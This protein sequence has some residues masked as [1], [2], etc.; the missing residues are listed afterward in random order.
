MVDLTHGM[1][2]GAMRSPRLGS[3]VRM[4][5]QA[6]NLEDEVKIYEDPFVSNEPQAPAS[7]VGKAVLEERPLNET[8]MEL[9]QSSDDH[10][11]EILGDAAQQGNARGHHRTTSTGSIVHC[12]AD[13]AAN[14]P[15]TIKNRQLLASGINKIRN[16]TV[17]AHMFRRLQEMIRSN[18]DIWGADDGRVGELLAASLD[19]LQAPADTLKATPMKAANLKVQVLA[20]IRA[21]LALYRKET[22]R[23]L[24]DVLRAVLQTKAQ[25]DS[26]SHIA[27]D[28]EATAD[29]VVRYGRTTDCL[30]AVVAVLSP[31]DDASATPHA[32]PSS[33]STAGS[34]AAAPSARTTT[35]AL[36]TLAALLHAAPA[37]GDG[38][39]SPAHTARLGRLAVRFL[40][41][42]DADVRKADLDFCLALHEHIGGEKEAFWKAVAGAREQHLNLITY[43]LARRGGRA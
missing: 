36:G 38:A 26:T 20:T 9:P 16:R 11:S 33:S 4:S 34:G 2:L 14:R 40:D 35:M 15:E 6:D 21:M 27:S 23:Y 30:D 12:D 41:A 13:A 39:L 7:D 24:A 25:H 31:G 5:A 17:D 19:Y 42:L 18:Q 1:S 29:E 43:F 32:S 28:L 8:S 10:G 37:K 3:P 22:A